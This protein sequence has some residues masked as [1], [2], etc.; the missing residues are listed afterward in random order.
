MKARTVFPE[1]SRQN[2]PKRM[3]LIRTVASR[4]EP[5]VSSQTGMSWFIGQCFRLAT[6]MM[7]IKIGAKMKSTPNKRK[8]RV[9]PNFCTEKQT[10]AWIHIFRLETEEET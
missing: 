1:R 8:M 10:N 9:Q 2:K 6:P 7:I 3:K 5:N 4:I